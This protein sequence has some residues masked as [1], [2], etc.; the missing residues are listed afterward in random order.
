[1][2]RIKLGECCLSVTDG[3]HGSPKSTSN[4]EYRFLNNNNLTDSGVVI[5]NGDRRIS[6]EAFEAIRRRTKLSKGDVLIATCGTL[7]KTCVLSEDPRNYDFSR[8]VGI[9]KPDSKKL[10]GRYLHYFFSLPSSQHRIE[11]IATGGVQKHFYIADMN[12]FDLFLPSLKDQEAVAGLLG[13]IDNKIALNKR[14]CADLEAIAKLLYDYWFVQFD[15]PDENGKPYK[16]SGGKM[17]W[18]EELKC[19]IPAAWTVAHASDLFDLERGYSYS[20]GDLSEQSGVP[21]ISLAC[22]G[23]KL[24]YRSE[25]LKHLKDGVEY[26][27][28][29]KPND[30][31]IACTDLT[32]GADIIG[33]PIRVPNQF[34]RYVYSMDLAKVI[35][36]SQDV[37]QSYLYQSL[38]TDWFHKF[39]KGHTSGTNV[40]H[41]NLDVF[42]WF[43]LVVPPI[44]LQKGYEKICRNLFDLSDLRLCE[45]VELE[46][47]RDFLLPLLMNGQVTIRND[48]K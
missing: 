29:V 37:K 8:S 6:K 43:A 1:M 39:A 2:N 35:N 34:D 30:M 38:R 42:K 20:S 36:L 16:S 11:R 12:D 18:N 19:E 3:E 27:S 15:F 31:L 10:D 40:I 13:T 46:T 4:G 14:L 5:N 44:E 21:F 7:G 33:C 45:N 41:L 26:A 24:D 32:R 28:W 47:I 23:R 17:V 9:I 22:F 25:E 48:G